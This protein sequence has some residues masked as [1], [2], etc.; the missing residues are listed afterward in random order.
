MLG[1]CLRR[2][3]KPR[4]C[5]RGLFALLPTATNHT[6]CE[7]TPA[8]YA[9][10]LPSEGPGPPLGLTSRPRPVKPSPVGDARPTH[11]ME[12]VNRLRSPPTLFPEETT[13][14]SR[15]F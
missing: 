13:T 9:A 12:R 6:V 15:S 2:G 8:A 3:L 10:S 14:V 7:L 1:S 4:A 5:L 11:G